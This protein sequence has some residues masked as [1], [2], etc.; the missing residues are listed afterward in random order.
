[1]EREKILEIMKN[2]TRKYGK[3]ADIIDE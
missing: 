2:M 1:V 3:K